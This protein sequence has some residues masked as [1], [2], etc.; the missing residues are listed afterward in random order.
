MLDCKQQ[1]AR[2]ISEKEYY[3]GAASCAGVECPSGEHCILR[4]SHCSKP[5]CKLLRSCA[6]M[7]GFYWNKLF[8]IVYHVYDVNVNQ[9]IILVL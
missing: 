8:L 6:K 2:C 7:T 9:L 5:P 1:I 4:E 3:E